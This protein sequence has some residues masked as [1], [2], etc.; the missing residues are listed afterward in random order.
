[1]AIFQMGQLALATGL[2]SLV[3][4]Y[5]YRYLVDWTVSS[6]LFYVVTIALGLVVFVIIRRDYV[7]FNRFEF[8]DTEFTVHTLLGLERRYPLTDYKWIP[9]LH[10]SANIPEPKANLSFHVEDRRSGRTV[11][12]YSW[13]GFSEADFRAVS[14]KYGYGGQTD[15]KLKD[16]FGGK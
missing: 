10:K 16:A 13:A 9:V 1:M 6:P 14:K 15:F 8:G 12:N 5:G 2:L 4:N 7:L 3:F 11:R